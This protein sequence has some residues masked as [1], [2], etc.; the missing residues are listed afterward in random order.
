MAANVNDILALV[1][2]GKVI[3]THQIIE[4]LGLEGTS[5]D[6]HEINTRLRKLAEQGRLV[7]VIPTVYL[8]PADADKVD[9]LREEFENE[10]LSVLRFDAM[11]PFTEIESIIRKN[12]DRLRFGAIQAILRKLTADK[13]I[14]MK[15]KKG[16]IRIPSDNTEGR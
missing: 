5:Y 9:A 13:K 16:Y 10:I 14:E 3:T 11:I 2:P 1:G 12:D 8:D 15:E 4:S 7:K 6:N